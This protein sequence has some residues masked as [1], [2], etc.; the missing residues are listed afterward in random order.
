MVLPPELDRLGAALTHAAA[1]KTTRVERRR[2]VAGSFAAGLFV[3]AAMSPTPLDRADQPLP[4]LSTTNAVAAER[5][6]Q[7]R[8]QRFDE[9]ACDDDTAPQAIR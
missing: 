7:P 3:I 2:R 4:F 9:A 1:R 5:C 6:D 8:G